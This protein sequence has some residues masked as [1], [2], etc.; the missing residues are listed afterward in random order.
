MKTIQRAMTS[1]IVLAL[2]ACLALPAAAATTHFRTG[3]ELAWTTFGTVSPDGCTYTETY[4]FASDDAQQSEPGAPVHSSQIVFSTYRWSFCS[5]NYADLL[6][7]FA[8]VQVPSD[9]F[10]MTGHL[11]GATLNV[12][13]EAIDLV[14]GANV[15]VSLNLVWTGI[16][17]VSH[18]SSNLHAFTP[19]Y[20]MSGHWSGDS[21]TAGLTGTIALP[22]LTLEPSPQASSGLGT[23]RNGT[24]TL[25][26]GF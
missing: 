12:T 8:L 4:L 11:Q 14:S 17:E 20:R 24:V 18:S 16:S 19:S 1:L 21:R 10:Q 26:R 3:T 2:Y 13:F 7:V 25:T 23:T 5:E 22:G 15:P 6:D 9:V